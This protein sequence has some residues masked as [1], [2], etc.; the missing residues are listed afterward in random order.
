MTR[1]LTIS[2]SA[3]VSTGKSD[4]ARRITDA[5]NA[6]REAVIHVGALLIEAK[7]VLPHGDFQA[8][9][10]AE[11][12]FGPRTAQRLMAIV[13]DERIT[14][15]T[16]GSLLPA[17]W[18]TL[19][20]LTRLDDAV[21]EGAFAAGD[22]SPD[23][24]RGDVARIRRRAA[25]DRATSA[26][27][28]VDAQAC[29]V[30]D[31]TEL[32]VSG[33]RFGAILADPPWTFETYSAKGQGRSAETHYACMDDKA[34]ADL[35]V[36]DLAADDC[37]LF[38]WCTWPK[39]EDA[40]W[41]VGQWGFDYKTVA[42]TWVKQK[43]KGGGLWTGMGFWTRSNPE[44]CLLATR[45]APKRLSGKVKELIVAPVREHSRKPAEARARIAQLVPGPYLELFARSQAEGWEAWGAEVGKFTEAPAQ[46]P[47]EVPASKKPGKASGKASGKARGKATAKA[48][49]KAPA[50]VVAK[51]AASTKSI[52]AAKPSPDVQRINAEKASSAGETKAG[53]KAR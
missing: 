45:G 46:V 35:P 53:E 17:S 24:E 29:A 10:D 30:E 11:L 4:W 38:L 12:P 37:V 41:I 13:A 16:H 21:L 15:T 28:A 34:I 47:A 31:L 14:N 36:K 51:A 50:M 22:I 8:M 3:K 5:W 32:A 33:A 7:D 1:N 23:M 2:A 43:P 42:F 44:P 49:G 9:V 18:R 48:R 19:Y 52:R 25:A 26:P 20:E 39:L 27:G 40:L 6:S